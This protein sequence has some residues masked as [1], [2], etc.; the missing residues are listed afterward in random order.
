MR[1]WLVPA[2]A[3]IAC[4][5][6]PAQAAETP[7]RLVPDWK[8][9]HLQEGGDLTVR[10]LYRL[11]MCLRVRNRPAAEAL[12]ASAPSSAEENALL[13]AAIPSGPTDCPIRNTRLAIRSAILFR[14][15]VAEA[16]YNGDRTRPRTTSALPLAETFEASGQGSDFAVARWVAR[17]AVRREPRLAHEVVKWNI[18]AF[19]ELRALRSLEPTFI[20]CLPPGKQLRISR[21][22]IRALIAEELYGAS[23]AYKEAFANAGS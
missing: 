1:A 16:L 8:Q 7:P 3:A 15:A 21:I 23:V 17:C 14:G 9:S 6:A 4:A 20:A 11:A 22:N 13:R 5:A 12:L 2:V 10:S 18:G 19:G